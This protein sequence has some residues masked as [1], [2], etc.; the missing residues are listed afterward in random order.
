MMFCDNS[1]SSI[2]LML[3]KISKQFRDKIHDWMDTID[4]GLS[5]LIDRCLQDLLIQYIESVDS[6]IKFY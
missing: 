2:E 6:P 1:A 5:N 3:I 4:D